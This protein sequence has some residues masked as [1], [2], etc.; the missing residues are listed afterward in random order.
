MVGAG[1]QVALVVGVVGVGARQPLG[2]LQGAGVGLQGALGC[3]PSLVMQMT[4]SL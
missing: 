3:W 1:R 2:D 4:A